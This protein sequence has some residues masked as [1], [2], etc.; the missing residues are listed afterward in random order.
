M[1][2]ASTRSHHYDLQRGNGLLWMDW[3]QLD[4]VW[5]SAAGPC[6]VTLNLQHGSYLGEFAKLPVALPFAILFLPLVTEGE[7]YTAMVGEWTYPI[8]DFLY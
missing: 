1:T 7:G 2:Q 5:Q 6:E 3:I 8:I 4:V